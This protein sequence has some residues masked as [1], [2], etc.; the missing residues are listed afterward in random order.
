M[1]LRASCP[2]DAHQGDPGDMSSPGRASSGVS[3]LPP[4]K[5]QYQEPLSPQR[6]CS[7]PLLAT[8]DSSDPEYS[9][10]LEAQARMAILDQQSKLSKVTWERGHPLMG[11]SL[12]PFPC[13]TDALMGSLHCQVRGYPGDTVRRAQLGRSAE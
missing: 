5:F 9:A 13:L 4:A 1:V 11:A 7:A 3:S 6:P 2:R 10:E 12:N 8:S